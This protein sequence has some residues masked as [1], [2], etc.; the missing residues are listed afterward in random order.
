SSRYST[1]SPTK[2]FPPRVR[3]TRQ[4]WSSWAATG[5]LR[6]AVRRRA[7][8][9]AVRIRAPWARLREGMFTVG[10]VLRRRSPGY[11]APGGPAGPGGPDPFGG[12]RGG[13][14]DAAHLHTEGDDDAPA[15]GRGSGR[16][17]CAYAGCAAGAAA[18]AALGVWRGRK[19][20]THSRV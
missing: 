5:G 13:R 14:A 7:G 20:R 11:P 6:S 1:T 9:A 12:P 4:A 19:R 3:P 17:S 10:K 8:R 2:L 15:A 16:A 18:A